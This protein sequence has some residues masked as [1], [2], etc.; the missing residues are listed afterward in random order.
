MPK[1]IYLW[2]KKQSLHELKASLLS[3]TGPARTLKLSETFLSTSIIAASVPLERLKTLMLMCAL[4][5]S[6]FA[7]KDRKSG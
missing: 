3:V 1:V 5:Q 7:A 4:S 6:L 2:L